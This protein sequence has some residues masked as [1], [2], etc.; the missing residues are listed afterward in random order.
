M[1]D[2]REVTD[3][4]RRRLIQAAGVAGAISLAGCS[5]A[6]DTGIE[7]SPGNG[8]DGQADTSGQRQLSEQRDY[9]EVHVVDAMTGRG[10][11]LVKLRTTGG[12]YY[13]TDSAGRVALDDPGLLGR[14]VF[15][16]VESHGYR[17]RPGPSNYEGREVDVVPGGKATIAIDRGNVA[18]RLYRVTGRGIYRD[19]VL[20]GYDVPLSQPVINSQVTG[21]DSVHGV[22]YDD[23][24]YWFWGDTHRVDRP[25]GNFR[26]AGATSL[27]PADGGLDPADGVDL[28]YFEDREGFAAE[29]APLPS[30]EGNLMWLDHLM[31]VPDADGEERLVAKYAHVVSLGVT[32]GQ[33]LL[34]FDDEQERFAI[35]EE[36]IE[37]TRGHGGQ[38]TQYVDPETGDSYWFVAH[39]FPDERVPNDFE[40]VQQAA[41]YEHFT[42]L[43]PGTE[44]KGVAS[45]IQR[46][47]D[48]NVV[49]A[50][51]PHTGPV[52]QEDERALI[53]AGLLESDE[54]HW[55]LR[56]VETGDDVI[57]HRASVAWNAHRQRWILIGTQLGGDASDIGEVWFSESESLTGPWRWARKI[58]THDDYSFY[59]PVQHPFFDQDGGR[60][61]Y[62]EGTY[63]E[64]FTR[65]AE[66]TPLYDYNQVMY[67]LDLEH[68][69]LNLPMTSSN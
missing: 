58:V 64:M 29:M 24:L 9:F 43:E 32:A 6:D 47:E 15:F 22:V 11:P 67:R 52:S 62:F 30:D 26:V 44:N 4:T 10:V 69:G 46:D 8:N 33:G 28:T 51:K 31:T 23:R 12:A 17:H 48:G 61:V 42:P 54:A 25:L 7:D 27:L 34:V 39:P 50:W 41:A 37:F 53:D 35:L 16:H 18:E 2:P 56:D 40:T 60:Y 65:S 66:P 14:R 19:S 55:Q 59:N 13:V 20:L 63:S 3:I 36:D 45:T 68:P 38:A 1:P 49:W 21:Q 5:G 57:V